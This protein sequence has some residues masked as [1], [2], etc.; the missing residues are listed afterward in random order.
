M[1]ECCTHVLSMEG[2]RNAHVYSMK[3]WWSGHFMASKKIQDKYLNIDVPCQFRAS[4]QSALSAVCTHPVEKKNKKSA[5]ATLQTQFLAHTSLQ[6]KKTK[7]IMSPARVSSDV[8][9]HTA[10][11]K[12]T[13]GQ[14]PDI[15]C[16]HK[17]ASAWKQSKNFWSPFVTHNGSRILLDFTLS[18]NKQGSWFHNIGCHVP[19]LIV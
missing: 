9:T 18:K 19:C 4:F 15:I 16:R 5:N 1:F 13:K 7:T 3:T 17:K 8:C 6:F 14:F 12:P 11:T 2:Y 10:L